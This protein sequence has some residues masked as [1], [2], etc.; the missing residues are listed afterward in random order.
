MIIPIAEFCGRNKPSNKV[1]TISVEKVGSQYYFLTENGDRSICY[2]SLSQ[3]VLDIT[4]VY[5]KW[6]GFK[7]LVEGCE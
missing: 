7:L 4:D 2:R 5:G 1:T 6:Y 3:A